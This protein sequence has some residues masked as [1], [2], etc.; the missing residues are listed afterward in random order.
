MLG[1]PF[2]VE[3]EMNI[4]RSSYINSIARGARV[5]VGVGMHVVLSKRL[6]N[7]L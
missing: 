1:A 4:Q 7:V 2:F 6:V 5:N 3:K